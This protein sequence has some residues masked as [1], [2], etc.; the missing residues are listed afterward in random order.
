VYVAVP[1][2]KGIMPEEIYKFYADMA[3]IVAA[4]IR[5]EQDEDDVIALEQELRA[6]V[7]YAYLNL[8]SKETFTAVWHQ[9]THIPEWILI[10][11]PVPRWWC[12]L[13][14]HNLKNYK[15]LRHASRSLE[16]NVA[17]SYRVRFCF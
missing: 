3:S 9:I 12:F 15:R 14:E 11:G 16:V 7:K 6:K 10:L 2:F 8:L 13:A 4:L 17:R 5:P 1:A